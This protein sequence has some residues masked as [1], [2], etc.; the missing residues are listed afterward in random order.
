MAE[1]G[2]LRS[3]GRSFALWGPVR[4]GAD[5]GCAFP[6]VRV[7]RALCTPVL[8]FHPRAVCLHMGGF[9][10]RLLNPSVSRFAVL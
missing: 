3:P 7:S 10:G 5:S 6:G 2:D 9:P 1:G 8:A 4:D